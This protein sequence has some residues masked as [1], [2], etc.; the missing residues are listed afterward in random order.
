M[1]SVRW[2]TVS[3]LLLH[4]VCY[5]VPVTHILDSPLQSFLEPFPN[6]GLCSNSNVRCLVRINAICQNPTALCTISF[7]TKRTCIKTHS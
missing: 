1:G 5:A 6:G 3:F 4:L 2:P 7:I